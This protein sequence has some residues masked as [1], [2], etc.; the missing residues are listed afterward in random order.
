MH[1]VCTLVADDGAAG[2]DPMC[3]RLRQQQ[4]F[5]LQIKC[6]DRYEDKAVQAFNACAVSSKQCVP[7]RVDEGVWPVRFLPA[8]GRTT[9]LMA[10]L[11]PCV[12][13]QTEPCSSVLC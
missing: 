5:V 1:A 3:H 11:Q 13:K 6:G 4:A 10:S 9:L 7:Q 8:R 12:M 2:N